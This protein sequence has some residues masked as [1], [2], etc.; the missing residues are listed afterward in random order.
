MASWKDNVSFILIEPQEPGNIGASARA[1]QNMG[2][3]NLELVR[4]VPF[5][6]KEAE[7]M[8]CHAY[9]LVA[10]ARVHDS[11]RDALQGKTLIVGTTR[12]KGKKRGLIMPLR[13]SVR[14][15]V[16]AA[17]KNPLAIL[18]GRERNGMTNEEVAECGFLITIPS[19]PEFPSLNLAQS[20]L[21]VAYELG[22]QTCKTA[23]PELIRHREL[24]PLYSR[25]EATLRLL[26]FIPGGDADLEKKIMKNLRHLIGR[27]GLTEWEL[28][29]LHGLCTQVEK[30]IK[31]RTPGTVSLK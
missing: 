31:E 28:K 23:C 22:Q 14:R 30:K 24:A 27:A 13:E 2:F 9:D 29:M 20:L 4:P 8:A 26:E 7:W 3:R 18:F 17:K 5:L 25:I 15:I 12:R 1:M 19:D 11:F 6:T 16:A 10:G 21:L